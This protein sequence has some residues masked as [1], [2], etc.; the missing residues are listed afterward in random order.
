MQLPFHVLL[1]ISFK[2]IL[3]GVPF[4][5][6]KVSQKIFFSVKK[7][8]NLKKRSNYQICLENKKASSRKTEKSFSL[9]NQ[10]PHNIGL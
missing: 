5:S 6:R 10:N 7:L 2:L 3:E 4:I 8:E 9:V 1:I